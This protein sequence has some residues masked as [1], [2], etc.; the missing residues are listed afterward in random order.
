MFHAPST[1]FRRHRGVFPLLLGGEEREVRA[2]V[3]KCWIVAES[4]FL[5]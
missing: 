2:N 3:S 1:M 4:L 5:L